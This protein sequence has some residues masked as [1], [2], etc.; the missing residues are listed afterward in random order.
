MC[1]GIA[2]QEVTRAVSFDTRRYRLKENEK[3]YVPPP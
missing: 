3:L 2:M 1:A